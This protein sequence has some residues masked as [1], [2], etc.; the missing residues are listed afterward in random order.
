MNM[1][2]ISYDIIS[3][4][5]TD[6]ILTDEEFKHIYQDVINKINHHKI[7][8]NIHSKYPEKVAE[9]CPPSY[10]HICDTNFTYKKIVDDKYNSMKHQNIN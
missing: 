1:Y 6:E 8:I 2:S 5:C 7:L 9:I 3:K 4:L 10:C